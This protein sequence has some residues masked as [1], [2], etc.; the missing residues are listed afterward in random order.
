VNLEVYEPIP[1]GEDI[2]E[3]IYCL[4]DL[5]QKIELNSG[6][7]SNLIN[8]YTY[9][10]S[11]SGATSETIET[12]EI[13]T[14]SV[15]VTDQFGCSQTRNITIKASNKASFEVKVNDF[16]E[17]NSLTIL[18]N[19]SSVGSYEYALNNSL[20]PY[21][22]EPY[23]DGLKPGVYNIYVRD[24]NGCG[25][26]KKTVGVKSIMKFFT[27]NQDGFNDRWTILGKYESN[28]SNAKIYI[29]DRFGKLLAGLKGS[30]LG[31][32]GRYNGKNMPSNDYWYKVILEDGQVFTG[33]FSLIR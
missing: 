8:N 15:T 2:P 10:W 27:P 21:Q 32:D 29:Y 17:N 20:G 7:P 31:W 9:L 18:L 13:T 5:P 12:N 11:P 30:S 14:H 24:L 19:E 23:F 6:I 25:I 26:T 16:S 1:I 3:I 4:E 28:L 22:P 33:N